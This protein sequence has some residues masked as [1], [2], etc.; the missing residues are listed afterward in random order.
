MTEKDFSIELDNSYYIK[1]DDKNINS[2]DFKYPHALNI[3]NLINKLQDE[4]DETLGTEISNLIISNQ[5]SGLVPSFFKT[6]ISYKDTTDLY[7]KFQEKIL[8]LDNS[9]I[10][11]N[12]DETV[13]KLTKPIQVGTEV[14]EELHFRTLQNGDDAIFMYNKSR[15][16][17]ADLSS[18]L[19]TRLNLEKLGESYLLQ[20]TSNDFMALTETL[21]KQASNS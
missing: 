19:I 2:I 6:E 11:S 3:K 10:T 1:I 13:L 17:P 5:V 21:G 7:N 12:G 8:S 4:K 20:M 16:P 9:E 14:Y 15:R 18:K